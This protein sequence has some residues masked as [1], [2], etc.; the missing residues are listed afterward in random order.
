V[1]VTKGKW[2]YAFGPKCSRIAFGRSEARK[3][4]PGVR[5]AAELPDPDQIP[6]PL[7]M[8]A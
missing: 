2:S 5:T 8:A 3:R 1:T 6:L 7:E 4:V